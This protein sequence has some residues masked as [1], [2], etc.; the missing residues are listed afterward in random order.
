MTPMTRTH[1]P[2]RTLT[3]AAVLAAL[4]PTLAGC[5]VPVAGLTGVTVTAEGEPLGVILVCHDQVDAA[6]LYPDE[7]V[8]DP[9]AEA[10]ADAGEPE[11]TDGWTSAVPVTGYA[12]W[13]LTTPPGFETATNFWTP[14]APP[15]ALK[16][17]RLY[18]L[19]GTTQD[20]SW[21]TGHHSF[22]PA[23]LKKLTPDQVSYSVGDT[24]R[25]TTVADFRAHA[26]EGF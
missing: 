16:P 9:G 8:T 2:R 6:V 4:L 7:P 11:Y 15:H 14:D 17:G 26:C 10:T 13:P 18:T 1:R 12:T 3:T 19:Y 24:V 21:A 25:T 22:T 23:D 20:S 5:T